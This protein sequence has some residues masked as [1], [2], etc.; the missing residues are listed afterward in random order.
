MDKEKLA[1]ITD[2]VT[3]NLVENELIRFT[4]QFFY[5]SEEGLRPF[6]SGVLAYIHK[7]HFIFTASHVADYVEKEGKDLY[8]RVGRKD[9]V[10]VLGMFR[11]TDMEMSEG[12]DLAY[13]KLD[14]QMIEPLSGPYK[15]L[16]IDKIR[17]HELRRGG[18]NYCVL[19][20][21]E[22]NIKFDTGRMETGASYFLT[23]STN[24]NPYKY[25]KYDKDKYHILTMRG[26]GLD[27]E[28][29]AKKKVNTHFHGISGCGL[30]YLE[31]RVD[32]QEETVHVDYRL[33]GILTEGRNGKYFCLI[34]NRIHTLI[35]ALIK[36]EGFK[37]K[38][39]VRG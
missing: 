19:G 15:F 18:L 26:K 20:Y 39:I 5:K 37:F 6:G 22:G 27:M 36:I 4:I 10:N 3:R 14:E 30:W 28:T 21:P 16:T 2:E 12:V 29:G 9:Y 1:R 13:I 17:K 11:Y 23:S 25:Y 8:I 31:Y 33:I 34:A 38:R 7:T 24:D 35:E 32:E